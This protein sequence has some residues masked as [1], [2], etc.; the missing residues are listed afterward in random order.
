MPIYEYVFSL[1]QGVNIYQ[2]I[3]KSFLFVTQKLSGKCERESEFHR[4]SKIP[5]SVQHLLV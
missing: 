1:L 5:L 3:V 4:D 2:V